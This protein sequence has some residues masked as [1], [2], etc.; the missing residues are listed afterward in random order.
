MKT[1]KFENDPFS[2]GTPKTET[3]E[4]AS[5]SFV[6]RLLITM[7]F[8]VAIGA[9]LAAIDKRLCFEKGINETILLEQCKHLS[10]S[11]HIY[12]NT[13]QCERAAFSSTKTDAKK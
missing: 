9:F 6:N 1:H 4:N 7:A 10:F 2:V 12:S 8:K 13:E 3:F 5:H 11:L